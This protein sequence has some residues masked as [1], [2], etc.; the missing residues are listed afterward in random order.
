MLLRRCRCVLWM[1]GML[2]AAMLLGGCAA[3]SDAP[4]P[5]G[6]PSATVTPFTPATLTP[7]PT[8]PP[9]PTVTPTTTP[10][11]SPTPCQA[12]VCPYPWRFPFQRPLAPP[13]DRI[14]PT[15][16]FGE[17]YHGR[18]D[19]H[20]GV[21]FQAPQGTPVLAAAEGVVVFAG[22]DLQTPV[23]DWR[24]FYGQAVV[25]AHTLPDQSQPLYTLYGHLDTVTVQVGQ[26]VRAGD[27]VGTVGSRGVALGPHL[28]FEVRWGQNTYAAAQNPVLWMQPTQ[29]DQGVLALR[30]TDAAGHR[31]HLTDIA[32]V[33]LA[34]DLP[35]QYLETYADPTLQGD[36][37]LRENAALG[38]LP[39]G[40]YRI[41]VTCCGR[42]WRRE[43][44][45]APQ[46]VT[47]VRWQL[48]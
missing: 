29:A 14:A 21:D 36:P 12:D 17:T 11:P 32:V 39:P 30:L 2:L 7:I 4:T 43:V 35:T 31:L 5:L 1:G 46:T 13:Y 28:H 9:S 33:G 3:P 19:P 40:Q 45:V 18:R 6:Q 37:R 44:V 26:Q 10:T 15:Y 25:L 24:N 41:E 47:F 16:R 34:A 27:V 22:D 42:L 8:L 38:D 20:H 48:P 23:S